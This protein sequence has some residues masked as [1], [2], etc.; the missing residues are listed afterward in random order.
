MKR[1]NRA[2]KL[3]KTLAIII[4]IVAVLS[5]ITTVYAIYALST[6]PSNERCGLNDIIRNNCVPP[7]RCTPL[8]NPNEAV[9]DCD[10]KNYARK[11]RNNL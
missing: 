8:G 5:T 9:V 3:P 6:A 11:Y 7:G 4:S 10:V 2:D 1:S